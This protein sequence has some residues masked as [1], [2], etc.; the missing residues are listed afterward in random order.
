MHRQEGPYQ[1]RSKVVLSGAVQQQVSDLIAFV[2]V[3][4]LSCG[5][6]AC[7]AMLEAVLLCDKDCEQSHIIKCASSSSPPELCCDP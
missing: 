1:V 2:L 3:R 5:V 6:E 7:K 4:F